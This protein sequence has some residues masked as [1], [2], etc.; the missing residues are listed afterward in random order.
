M[1]VTRH[2]N[3]GKYNESMPDKNN[4]IS[5]FFYSCFFELD[6]GKKLCIHT[7]KQ[8]NYENSVYEWGL[9]SEGGLVHGGGRDK[10]D[11]YNIHYADFYKFGEYYFDIKFPTAFT[12][13]KFP[14]DKERRCVIE[15]YEKNI[16]SSE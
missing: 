13:S 14:T 1:K 9:Y 8:Y 5:N 3:Y 6:N 15:Y 7:F 4:I 2:H 11:E 10:D 12:V 16:K